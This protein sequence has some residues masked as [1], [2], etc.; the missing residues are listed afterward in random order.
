[1]SMLAPTG[2]ALAAA[3]EQ[4]PPA[5][6]PPAPTNDFLPEDRSIGECIS[7]VPK[8]GCGSEARGGWRQS[9]V[10]LAIL[11]GLALIVWRIVASARRA[12]EEQTA[13]S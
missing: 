6:P 10:L 7:A 5:T 2:V 4:A 3:S 1:M 12:R 13:R 11:V 8:P 9:L